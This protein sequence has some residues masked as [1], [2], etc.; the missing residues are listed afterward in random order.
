MK[1]KIA[2]ILVCVLSLTLIFAM[3]G[4]SKDLT[5]EE[6]LAILEKA[7]KNTEDATT[8]YVRTIIMNDSHNSVE[9]QYD[10]FGTDSARFSTVT[11]NL[12][13]TTYDHKYFGKSLKTNVKPKNA[14]EADWKVCIFQDA[15]K[16]GKWKVTENAT[17]EQFA[18]IEIVKKNDLDVVAEKAEKVLEKLRA[19]TIKATSMK[20]MGRVVT[21]QFDNVGKE[22]AEELGISAT[23]DGA[24][25]PLLI[26]ITNEKISKFID[27]SENP[28]TKHYISYQGPK[29]VL[30]NW[31]NAY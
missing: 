28:K 3:A 8:F 22:L 9:Y 13:D 27:N 23:K 2:I 20:I 31:D 12:S 24:R 5:Q 11:N 6:G 15:N 4:C 10:V 30:P 1:K 14:T 17:F 18:N 29:V 26:E 21:M 16:D 7:V 25:Y 19:G